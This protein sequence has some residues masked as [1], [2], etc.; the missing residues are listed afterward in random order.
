MCKSG[1]LVVRVVSMVREDSAVAGCQ[2]MTEYNFF[3]SFCFKCGNNL[4][5]KDRLH[6]M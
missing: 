5:K 2:A 3:F 4:K 6:P 1:G